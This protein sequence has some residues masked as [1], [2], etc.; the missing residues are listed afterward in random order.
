MESQFLSPSTPSFPRP[1]VQT[2]Y[3]LH[4]VVLSEGGGLRAGP[5]IRTDTAH[6]QTAAETG[7]TVEARPRKRAQRGVSGAP[8]ARSG[9]QGCVRRGGPPP[10]LGLRSDCARA[11]GSELGFERSQ[12]REEAVGPQPCACL[13]LCWGRGAPTPAPPCR[14]I[15]SGFLHRR[16]A[17]RPMPPAH[18]EAAVMKR[19]RRDADNGVILKY[20]KL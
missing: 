7:G 17:R 15:P 5:R 10:A 19:P 18:Q 20:W 6:R 1:G 14:P 13:A 9:Q 2:A 11:G 12:A 3:R 16:A 4:F 8:R